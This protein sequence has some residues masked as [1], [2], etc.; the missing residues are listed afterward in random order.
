M[1]FKE[2]LDTELKRFPGIYVGYS[3]E[4]LKE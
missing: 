3:W 2:E 4:S 1:R